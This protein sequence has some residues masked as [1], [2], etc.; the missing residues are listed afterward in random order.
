MKVLVPDP[1]VLETP[2]K[3]LY[4]KPLTP[5]ELLFVRNNQQ[6]KVMATLDPVAE[7][8]WS[9][10]VQDKAI[11]V[12]QLKELP[13][14]S[15]T[16]VL[17]CSGNGRSLF[18]KAAQTKGTQWGKGGMGCVQVGGVRLKDVLQKLKLEP[19]PK[20]QY[21]LAE[22]IDKPLPDKEDFLHTLPLDES[23]NRSFVALSLNGKPLP[24]IHGGP[25]RLITPGV[26][27][28][29][30]IKW[31]GSLKFVEK[32]SENYNHVPRYRVPKSPIRPGLDFKFTLDNSS[33]NWN[34]KVKT[35]VLSVENG[36]KVAKGIVPIQGVAFNDGA[37]TIDTVLVSGDRGQTWH[38]A[39]LEK[40]EDRFAWTRFEM[41]FK[42]TPGKKEIWTR[43]IDSH[44]R[45]QPLNGSVAWNPRGY[46]WNGV[47]KIEFEV[48]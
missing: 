10:G 48:V 31:L 40:P 6:P 45:S 32:E 24:A 16:M 21:L 27:A 37:A 43:A 22:G 47:E 28:T 7:D 20:D 3:L 34:M 13:Q 44:G 23:I 30:N 41:S 1:A 39:R 15:V 9:I 14:S 46:E 2:L 12:R 38:Q 35:V 33:F 5:S 11:S 42:M 25:V 19:G 29:M 8:D 17:Q 18:S 26:Y 36:Q 4:D